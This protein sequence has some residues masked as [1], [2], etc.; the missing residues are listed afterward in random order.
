M[1][2]KIEQLEA[3]LTSAKRRTRVV[4]IYKAADPDST[5]SRQHPLLILTT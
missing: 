4:E 2:S 1:E 3:E 5:V